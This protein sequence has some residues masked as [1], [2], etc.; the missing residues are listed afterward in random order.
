MQAFG[1]FSTN[2]D[3]EY[4]TS[5]YVYFPNEEETIDTQELE[6]MLKNRRKTVA[7]TIFLYN[8]AL[9][10]V[11]YSKDASLASQEYPFDG[12]YSELIQDHTHFLIASALK[13]LYK[14]KLV[15]IKYLFNY[16]KENIEPTYVLEEFDSDLEKYNTN[17]L[18]RFDKNLNYLDIAN[19]RLNGK[20][21][22]F[23]SGHKYD[24]HHKSIIAYAEALSAQVQK[25]G[26]EIAF[27]HDK[28]YSA[29]EA[30]EKAYFLAPLA[31]GGK[32]KDIR[33]NAF[34]AAF[35]TNP[36]TIQRIS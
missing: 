14:G 2:F 3:H 28:N 4:L 18:T 9:T 16:N 7:G 25:L 32:L 10:P 20:F 23:G 26:K 13:K 12:K 27:I 15:E 31:S 19:I 24:R 29:Q 36:P 11:G 17:L 22:F 21:V 34:K 5:H 1:I 8:P 33:A 6:A 35:S 30:L